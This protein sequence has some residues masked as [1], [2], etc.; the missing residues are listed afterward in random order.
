L[1][2]QLRPLPALARCLGTLGLAAAC[3][4]SGGDEPAVPPAADPLPTAVAPTPANR[5]PELL[6]LHFEPDTPVPGQ[7]IS[8][9]AKASDAD[10][11][12]V[13]L[14]Y[15]WRLDGEETRRG[16]SG[17]DIPQ[18]AKGSYLEVTVVAHD[19]SVESDPR[20]LGAEVRN[21]P[22][23]MVDLLIEPASG[24]TVTSEIVASPRASDADGDPI[25]FEYTWLVNDRRVQVFGATLGH[26]HF[27]RGD[28][29][30][31]EVRASDGQSESEP[32][33]AP[34]I[35]IENSVPVVTSSPE[36]FDDSGRFRYTPVVEDADGDRRL[37][38]SLLQ[39]PEGM[40]IDWLRGTLSWAPNADQTGQHEI[41]IAVD[42]SAGGVATQVFVLEV[43]LEKTETSPAAPAP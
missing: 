2:R 11:D 26:K 3:G 30:E 21:Q 28:S 6:E 1:R 8:A 22:P 16:E 43:E 13:R 34:V 14:V 18:E 37:R 24:V 31:V 23:K 27:S 35:Q 38:F 32:I 20:T 17:F 33:R 19:G 5:P 29:V 36:G 12:A 39:A 7:R 40:Q 42:D 9:R 10:G 4:C 41:E 25:E 15:S